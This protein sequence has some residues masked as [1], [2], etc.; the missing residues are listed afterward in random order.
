MENIYGTYF[1]SS[2]RVD[3]TQIGGFGIGGK[4]PLAYKR[5][6][7]GKFGEKEYDNSYNI[8]TIYNGVKYTYLVYE[9]NETPEFNLAG[10]ELT[11]EHNGT[12]VQVPVLERDLSLFAKEMVRQLYYFENIIFEGFDDEWRYKETLINE[13]QIVRGKT[14]LYRGNEYSGAMHVCLGRVAY[15]I[16]YS[17]LGLNSSDY[18][19]PIAVR[20]EVGDINVTASREQIDYSETTIK[21][22][23]KKLEEVKKEITEL[24]AKQYSNIVTLEDYFMVKNNFGILNFANGMS[25]N[26]GNLI[27]Q[28]DV[29]FSNFKYSFMKMPCDKKL[30]RF[31][32]EVKSYGKKP[33]RSRYSSKYE[34]D[35]GY[36]ELKRNANLLYIE[37]EFLRKVV[38]QA[39]L[40]SEYELYH[41]IGKR[42]LV[43]AFIRVEIA[44]LFNVHLDALADA[45]GKPV[46]YVQSLFDMQE[47]YFNIVRAFAKDY[48][49]IEV[50]E[51]FV[52][53]R[54]NK[55]LLMSKEFRNTTIPVNFI[56]SGRRGSKSRI[57]L[58]TL[59]NYNQP[60]F[61]GTKEEEDEL[62]KI[63]S[64]YCSLFDKNAPVTYFSKYDNTLS[65]RYSG[66]D[67]KIKKSIMFISLAKNN[68]KYMEYCKKAYKPS[69]FF[70]RMLYRKE[71][72][73]II[74]FQ[75]YDLKAKWNEVSSF[76]KE[77]AFEKINNK[78]SKK[79]NEINAFIDALPNASNDRI[80]YLK[81][82]LS[83]YFDLSNVHQTL[84]QKRIGRLIAEVL[85]LQKDNLNILEYIDMP[86][87][88]DKAKDLFF[89]ILKKIMVL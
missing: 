25:I 37:G 46:D 6:I 66:D 83:K 12:E 16:D 1:E 23:K 75:T 70:T 84:E 72:I 31:F 2:K 38:K 57:K 87:D 21:V 41:I 11:T 44:E 53:S 88:I 13:Y 18:N 47:E 28:S 85:K 89:N 27:K 19:L 80:G 52:Q 20:L 49:N 69:E 82:E 33:T 64:M 29:D 42:N 9:G 17:V 58:D 3:N 62:E 48:D 15:P 7:E 81:E 79:I 74:Y 61:Y 86:Y 39:Y 36:D 32:F 54:K 5:K 63:Y 24:I 56:G 71:E 14:F 77:S 50:P 55:K 67:N 40:K 22:L 34:F 30:F 51:D 78:W 68:I 26:V 4:T 35:G 59:F 76:Y 73:V 65:N 8:V 60:I 45:N 10:E 43:D